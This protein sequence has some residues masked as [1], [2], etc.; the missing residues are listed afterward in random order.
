MEN[1]INIH[2]KIEISLNVIQNANS[3]QDLVRL[4]VQAVIRISMYLN[5]LA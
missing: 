5:L 2:Q 1:V 3:V 4:I